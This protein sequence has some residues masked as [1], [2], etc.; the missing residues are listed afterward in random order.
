MGSLQHQTHLHHLEKI[1][2]SCLLANSWR[3]ERELIVADVQKCQW[4]NVTQLIRQGCYTIMWHVQFLNLHH[5]TK[6]QKQVHIHYQMTCGLGIAWHTF[7]CDNNFSCHQN[8]ISSLQHQGVAVMKLLKSQR[9]WKGER[10][11]CHLPPTIFH[12]G[13]FHQANYRLGE[14]LLCFAIGTKK[15]KPFISQMMYISQAYLFGMKMQL[16]DN[17]SG[18]HHPITHLVQ[19]DLVIFP[20]ST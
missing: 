20:W 2:K 13:H 6:T 19:S 9:S 12:L 10:A 17:W 16:I 15:G 4:A 7:N 8:R 1:Q 18:L 5:L 11:N 14:V 3:K